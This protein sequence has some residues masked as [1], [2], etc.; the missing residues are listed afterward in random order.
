[1]SNG[2][3]YDVS[4]LPNFR[5]DSLVKIVAIGEFSRNV[6]INKDHIVCIEEVPKHVEKAQDVEWKKKN[7]YYEGT[8]S[9]KNFRSEFIKKGLIKK[10]EDRGTNKR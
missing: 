9:K 1:M 7:D 8:K 2:R 4:T 10:D 6:F 5:S 3:F